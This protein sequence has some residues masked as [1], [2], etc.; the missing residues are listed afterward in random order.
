M[1][2][3]ESEIKLPIALYRIA[4]GIVF[5]SVIISILFT[6]WDLTQHGVGPAIGILIFNFI[7]LGAISYI[8]LNKILC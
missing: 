2:E 4:L 1:S 5:G 7:S 8:I 3:E 6:V